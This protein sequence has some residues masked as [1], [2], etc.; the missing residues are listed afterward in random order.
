[1][2]LAKE[3][4]KPVSSGIQQLINQ[5]RKEGVKKG[6]AEADKIIANAEAQALK[7]F[8]SRKAEADAYFEKAQAEASKLKEKAEE[9]LRTVFRDA[10]LKMQEDLVDSFTK[11]IQRLV[12]KK[13]M[14]EDMLEQM[15]LEAVGKQRKKA[16]LDK[17]KQVEVLLPDGVIGL[18]FLRENPE[19]LKKGRLSQIVMAATGDLLRDGVTFSSTK[20]TNAGIKV[21]LKKEKVEID[22]SDKALAEMLMEHLQPRFRAILEGVVK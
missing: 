7:L 13:T 6:Q 12:A 17:A 5:L 10:L 16:K 18:D 1:M 9:E 3:K 2:A 14:D 8:E 22:M 11:K 4:T 15:I 19:R 21:F 20:N